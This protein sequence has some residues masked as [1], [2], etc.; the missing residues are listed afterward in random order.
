MAE[1]VMPK[2]IL[3][4]GPTGVGKTELARRLAQAGQFAVPE[5]GGQQVH[6]SRLCRPR[7]GVHDSRSGGYRH[8]HGARGAAGRSGR[9]RREERRGAAAR[10]ADAAAAGSRR[11][12][13][14]RTREKLRERLRDGKLDERMVEIDVKDRGP[15]VR[16]HHQRRHGRDGHQSEGHAARSVR[17][18]YAQTQDARGRSARLPGAGRRAEADRHGPGDAR[19][20]GARGAQ[21]HHLPGRDRQD[22]RARRRATAPTSAAKACSATFCPSWKAPRSTRATASCAPI[23]SC[24]S[25][26]ARFTSP[27]RAT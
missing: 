1:E 19:G 26:R 24:S 12:S 2:N 10:S 25:R 20:A 9:P 5:S 7:R 22:R 4:I 27:S 14:E 17:P 18:A 15:N 21:R 8:R 23:T 13:A 11:E 6:R 16:D 3:M